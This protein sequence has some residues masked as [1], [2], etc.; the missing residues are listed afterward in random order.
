[1]SPLGTAL[2]ASSALTHSPSQQ[3]CDIAVAKVMLWDAACF[4]WCVLGFIPQRVHLSKS[5]SNSLHQF[6]TGYRAEVSACSVA[7]LQPPGRDVAVARGSCHQR[8]GQNPWHP[9]GRPEPLL[10]S[11]AGSHVLRHTLPT[12]CSSSMASNRV[13]AVGRST[14]SKGSQASSSVL[15]SPALCVLQ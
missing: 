1:M 11:Q 9:R 10:R 3:C 7:C 5:I 14:E 2:H 12:T 8:P 15:K 13:P 4:G 6:Y